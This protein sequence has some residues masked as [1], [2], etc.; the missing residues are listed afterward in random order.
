MT[1]PK[2]GQ[3]TPQVIRLSEKEIRIIKKGEPAPL[4]PQK[5]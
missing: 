3:K 2:A 4:P 5:K 1:E